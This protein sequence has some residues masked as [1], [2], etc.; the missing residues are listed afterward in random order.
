MFTIIAFVSYDVFEI[1]FKK[2]TNAVVNALEI[3]YISI[4]CAHVYY[5][6]KSW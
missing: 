1:D 6:E 3:D 4:D 2:T 5:N